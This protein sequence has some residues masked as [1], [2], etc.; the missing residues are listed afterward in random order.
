M[1]HKMNLN[2]EP[3]RCI[4]DNTKTIELRLND[5]KRQLLNDNDIIEFTNLLTSESLFV[6]IVKLHRFKDFDELYKCFDKVSIGYGVND[7]PDPK[8][9]E[10]Y[11]SLDMQNKYGVLGIEIAVIGGEDYGK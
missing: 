3:F 9:M 2:D 10:L 1:I 11:Y 8:D 6:K 5:E 4:K 7:I